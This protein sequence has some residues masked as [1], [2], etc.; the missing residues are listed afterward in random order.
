LFRKIKQDGNASAKVTSPR[1]EETK[2]NK[3]CVKGGYYSRFQGNPENHERYFEN[4]F[5]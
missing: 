4:I 1:K 2:I 3:I 5:Q